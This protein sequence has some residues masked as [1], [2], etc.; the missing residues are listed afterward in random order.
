MAEI[1]E[2]IPGAFFNELGEKEATESAKASVFFITN[3]YDFCKIC[4]VNFI[5]YLV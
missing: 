1:R 5:L 3:S 4:S 2:T